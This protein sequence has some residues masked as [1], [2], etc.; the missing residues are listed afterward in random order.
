MRCLGLIPA[1]V[2]ESDIGTVVEKRAVEFVTAYEIKS[3]SRVNQSFGQEF[4]SI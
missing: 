4:R 3:Y 2:S 1:Q